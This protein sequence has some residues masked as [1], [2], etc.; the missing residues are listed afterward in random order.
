MS[1]VCDVRDSECVRLDKSGEW[2]ERLLKQKILTLGSTFGG[3]YVFYM[4][5]IDVSHSLVVVRG[6]VFG[7]VIGKILFPFLEI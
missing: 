2:T 6:E 1:C 5:E 4:P 7:E 3:K